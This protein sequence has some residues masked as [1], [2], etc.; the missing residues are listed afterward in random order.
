MAAS[1]YTTAYEINGW[2]PEH[3]IM[4]AGADS[5]WELAERRRGHALLIYNR[6]RRAL[7]EAV[8]ADLIRRSR[9]RQLRELLRSVL[10]DGSDQFGDGLHI[11]ERRETA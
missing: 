6:L 3:E 5:A 2:R 9:N 4:P 8:A 11:E 10:I 7:S 1:V